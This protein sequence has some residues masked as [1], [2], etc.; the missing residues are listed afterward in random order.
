[1]SRL[2]SFTL[3][4]K[5][6]AFETA[7]RRH[8]RRQGLE[9]EAYA[10]ATYDFAPMYAGVT[11]V[12]VQGDDPGTTDKDEAGCRRRHRLQPLPDALQL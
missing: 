7:G 10:S 2:K 5:T 12:Y 1:M 4:G 3:T 11:L 9:W 6:K 8:R